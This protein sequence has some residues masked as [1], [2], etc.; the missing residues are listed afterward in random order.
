MMNPRIKE[1]KPNPDYTLTLTFA[2]DEIKSFDIKPY[3]EKGIFRE[4]KNLSSFNS[5]K[6]F[7]GSIQ[8]Q[9]GKDF[10]PDTLYLDGIILYK[11]G[12]CFCLTLEQ[13][14]SIKP[15][16]WI[17]QTALE[18]NMLEPFVREQTRDGVISY[19]VSFYGPPARIYANEGVAQVLFFASGEQCRVSYADRKDK[20]Q[21]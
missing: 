8:W 7:L 10:C 1:V 14:T 5:V 15:D 2:N 16:K 13:A 20:Y 17:E 18:H 19:G 11:N 4:L 9:N 6:P 12:A 21:G 3:L